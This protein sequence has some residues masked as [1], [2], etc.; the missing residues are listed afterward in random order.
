M[1]NT[2]NDKTAEDFDRDF[3]YICMEI[4]NGSA[5]RKAIPSFMSLEKFYKLLEGSKDK[6][7]RYAH[8]C[9]LRADKI[10]DD[11]ID[12][13]DE[14]GADKYIDDNGVERTDNEAIQRS[15][16]RIETR[17]WVLAKLAP[18]KYGDKLEVDANIK[19]EIKTVTVFKL[20]D[21]GR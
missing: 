3:E 10:F 13:S 14:A 6:A 16:L 7:K 1:A 17:K 2:T 20:P 4:E 12:I 11:L 19:G 8:A 18:K 21:N 15:K 9:D 5:A